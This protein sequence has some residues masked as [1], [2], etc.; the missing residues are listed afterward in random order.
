MTT[1]LKAPF[2]ADNPELGRLDSLDI[3]AN[4]FL[5]GAF[6]WSN[7]IKD[8]HCYNMCFLG[9]FVKWNYVLKIVNKACSDGEG[10]CSTFCFPT[11]DGGICGCQ[12][13]VSLLPNNKTCVGG[14][15]NSD[16]VQSIDLI[17][18]FRQKRDSKIKTLVWCREYIGMRK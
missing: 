16:I 15:H 4:N 14:R 3:F 9:D 18:S 8:L 11:P 17:W 2:M 5:D 13:N 1:G 6:V 7:K 10:Q 12:D